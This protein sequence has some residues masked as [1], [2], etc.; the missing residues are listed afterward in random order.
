M[1]SDW[2]LEDFISTVFHTMSALSAPAGHLPLEGK[3][4]MLESHLLNRRHT[5][6]VNLSVPQA[7]SSRAQPSIFIALPPY[8]RMR[9]HSNDTLVLPFSPFPRSQFTGLQEGSLHF[10]R[11][12]VQERRIASHSLSHRFMDP[13]CAFDAGRLASQEGALMGRLGASLD[14]AKLGSPSAG[15]PSPRAYSYQVTCD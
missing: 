13:S 3:A 14:E 1:T 9:P 15:L 6:L 12:D 7:P 11:D 5:T 4:T 10:G 8:A 2:C